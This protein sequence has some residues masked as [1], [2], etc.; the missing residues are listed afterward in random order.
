MASNT[1]LSIIVAI[2]VMLLV[3]GVLS[4][5]FVS[6]GNETKET[7][8]GLF[9]FLDDFKEIFRIGTPMIS[10]EELNIKQINNNE[11]LIIDLTIRRPYG[12]IIEIYL[13][14]DSKYQHMEDDE[15]ARV[16]ELQDITIRMPQQ[17]GP[18][19]IIKVIATK[20]GTDRTHTLATETIYF[21]RPNL[22]GFANEVGNFENTNQNF[23]EKNKQKISTIHSLCQESYKYCCSDGRICNDER[24]PCIVLNVATMSRYSSSLTETQNHLYLFSFVDDKC[25]AYT[26]KNNKNY[27]AAYTACLPQFI[28]QMRSYLQNEC[29]NL[30]SGV[31]YKNN[32]YVFEDYSSS[33]S[34]EPITQTISLEKFEFARINN[35]FIHF[36]LKINNAEGH[37]VYLVT[38]GNSLE[39]NNYASVSNPSIFEI[40]D[41][42]IP[43]DIRNELMGEIEVV[44]RVQKEG[45]S[46]R[47]L[48]ETK[49]IKFIK[50]N[51][52]GV[53]DW[54]GG[55]KPNVNTPIETNNNEF[56][57]ENFN[58]LIKINSL[59]QETYNFC[60]EGSLKDCLKKP[61]SSPCSV[62]RPFSNPFNKYYSSLDVGKTSHILHRFVEATNAP[63]CGNT[64]YQ[65][66]VVPL[67]KLTNPWEEYTYFEAY[68]ECL[69]VF[70]QQL[71]QYMLP[72][73]CEQRSD[74][75]YNTELYVKW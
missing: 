23:F 66:M 2:I 63:N 33:T 54:I 4:F 59:C 20:D 3:M 64:D 47:D 49:K 5:A 61:D 32:I 11:E 7:G 24:N 53:E 43:V 16:A 36:N 57:G 13:D 42:Q 38:N 45:F 8:K 73:K 74:V 19:T 6:V 41:F 58:T 22:D 68:L 21:I 56:W 15:K 52:Q 51:L 40:N 60:C 34:Q 29:R 65:R 46:I 55:F 1:T 70:L 50:S 10:L 37:K 25:T 14:E 18:S 9:S 35:G 44:I 48:S 26:D 67:F 39:L 17:W 31:D 62:I 28:S 71:R 12:Y 30:R 72:S 75:N 27:Y 69:P